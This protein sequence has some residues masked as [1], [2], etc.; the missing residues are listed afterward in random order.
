MKGN[1]TTPTRYQQ[2]LLL[3][4]RGRGDISFHLA[5]LSVQWPPR[6]RTPGTEQLPPLQC[7]AE[8]RFV[9]RRKRGG[10]ENNF[11]KEISDFQS[12][13]NGTR[14]DVIDDGRD[15]DRTAV[16]CDL[17]SQSAARTQE[18]PSDVLALFALY[19]HCLSSPFIIL[20]TVMVT[21]F[22]GPGRALGPVCMSG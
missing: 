15:E 5:A 21:H 3:V 10:D 20:T 19:S 8:C 16:V 9:L 11:E 12:R 14:D 6:I 2:L 17:T 18:P 4:A 22:S 1:V 7:C 13:L